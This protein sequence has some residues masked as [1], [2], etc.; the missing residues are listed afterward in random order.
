MT[1][2]RILV[3]VVVAVFA[4]ASWALAIPLKRYQCINS[5][6]VLEP[7]SF[8]S[9]G[10][11]LAICEMTCGIGSL[12]PKPT[13]ATVSSFVRSIQVKEI[14]LMITFL[15]HTNYASSLLSSMHRLF[16]DLV[17]A[18][19]TE[20]T[21]VSTEL[22]LAIK[23]TITTADERLGLG[24]NESYSLVVDVSKSPPIVITAVSIYGYRHALTTLSQLIEYD[25]ITHTMQIVEAATIHDKPVFPHRG[26]TLDTSRN[27]YS[28]ASIKRILDG[29]ALNKL[30]TFHWH[31][32][33]THSFPL[34]IIG[35]PRLT[36]F[37]AYSARQ[38]YSQAD[39]RSLVRYAKLRGIRVIPE[40]DA[41]AHVGAGWQWGPTADLGELV[42]CYDHSPWE[43]ACVEPPCGQLNPTNANIYP[44]LQTIYSEYHA[45]FDSDVIHMGG[46]E[47]HFGCWNMSKAVT[48][49][50]PKRDAKAFIDLW[51]NFQKKARGLV[52][53][54]S[55]ESKLMLW[56]SDLTKSAN[57]QQYLNP[58]EYI[59][60]VW[61]AIGSNASASLARLGYQVVLSNYD[62]WYLDCGFGNWLSKGTSWCDPVKSWPTIYSVNMFAGMTPD[63]HQFV[64]GGEGTAVLKT[65][66]E[67]FILVAL[68]S[69]M[70]DENSADLKLWPRTAAAAERLWSNPNSSWKDA[71]PRLRRQRSRLVQLGIRADAMQ[72]QWCQ[73]HPRRCGL[74]G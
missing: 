51:G 3:L 53:D 46:D 64:L 2:A 23:A 67:K 29:M 45:L 59:I 8:T 58:S 24:T 30:N 52:H 19:A 68:W 71:L 66:F 7:L 55:P 13:Q 31:L 36:T 47:V 35:E 21:E 65:W 60:Q 43:A 11:S 54:I 73:D 34:E 28:V 6:C 16:T 20:C 49:N 44:I 15:D 41:P 14:P 40:L 70:A 9:N 39:I 72:P 10:T 18:K 62:A 32:T 56:T 25:E 1:S 38:I 12:W 5:I 69:E 48:D 22:H 61:D 26:L 57:I 27:Y 74:L 42:V 63:L 4:T 37:G 33:D 50:M 17:Q